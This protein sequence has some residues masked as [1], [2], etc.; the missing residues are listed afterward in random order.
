MCIY[1]YIYVYIY[2]IYIYGVMVWDLRCEHEWM[3]MDVRCCSVLQ[4]A[5]VCHSCCWMWDV[6][7]CCR[8]LQYV[9]VCCSSSG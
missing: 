9:A 4:Y 6:A 7:V 2:T 5:A 8:V 1:I 3:W